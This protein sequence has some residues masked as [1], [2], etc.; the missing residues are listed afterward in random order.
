MK[1]QGNSAG[2]TALR[3]RWHRWTAI[4][5]LFARGR[6][7]RLGVDPEEYCRLHKELLETCRGLA[8]DPDQK[9]RSF[10]GGLEELAQPWL[11]P[12]I[13]AQADREITLDLLFR[14]QLAGQ[15]LGGG[16]W[17]LPA[18]RWTTLALGLAAALV[19]L[20]GLMAGAPEAMAL[21]ALEHEQKWLLAVWSRL[22]S[23]SPAHYWLIGS[24]LA[25]LLMMYLVS[26]TAKT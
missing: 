3:Q 9:E 25:I 12:R 16:S 10:Y 14:C 1:G 13:L 4:V 15:K 2:L 22:T 26:R 11:T 20:L 21:P 7:G 6:R 19:L 23:L 8:D 18:W 5:E 17:G 24:L